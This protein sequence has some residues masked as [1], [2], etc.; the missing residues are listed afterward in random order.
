M[1]A[2][3]ITVALAL[4]IL[5]KCNEEPTCTVAGALSGSYEGVLAWDMSGR[6]SCGITDATSVGSNS[7]FV[8][9]DDDSGLTQSLYVVPEN[10]VLAVGTFPARVLFVL[11]QNF[12]DSQASGCEVEVT[13]FETEE[14]SRIDFFRVEGRVTCTAP[15]RSVSPDYDDVTVVEGISFRAH[16]HAEEIDDGF[17]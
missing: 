3:H 5:S 6:E 17:L 15:L 10:P 9:Q 4:L 13:R 7:A 12:W 2:R 8:F 11:P 14:W 1:V 16:V